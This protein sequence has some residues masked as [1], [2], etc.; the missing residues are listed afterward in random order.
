M[1]HN[2]MIIKKNIVFSLMVLL[3]ALMISPVMAQEAATEEASAPAE[4]KIEDLAKNVVTEP[5]ADKL[6]PGMQIPV[7]GSS[8][9]AFEES[10]AS[11]KSQ[12]QEPNYV[13]LEQAIK[14][15]LVY[16]LG[17]GRDKAKLAKNL[18]GLTGDQIIDKVE[19]RK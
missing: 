7:D 8:L 9:E 10:L 19:W 1:N 14:Y 12:A 2:L 4:A 5:A 6:D 18:D 16:D 11:I 13:S 3:M 15:L 17:A